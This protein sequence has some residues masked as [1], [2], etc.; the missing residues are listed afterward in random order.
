MVL[1]RYPVKSMGGEALER[2][3][4]DRRGLAGDRWY[5]VED[6]DGHLASGKNTRRFRRRDAVFDYRAR[7]DG[8]TVVVTGADGEWAAED[9]ALA[10]A[11]SAR[12]GLPVRVRS[13]S[14]VPHQDRGAVSLVGTATLDWCRRRWGLDADPRRL[15]VNVVLSTSV[16][17]AEEEWVGRRLALGGAELAVVER[18]PRCRMVDIDQDGAS[19]RGGWLRPLAAEREMCIAVY[20]DVVTGGAV[21]LGDT[22]DVR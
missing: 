6:K 20:A 22:A 12:M 21:A 1:R 13:E 15:R 11:L 4:F 9:P 17:F 3:V 7:T 2:A 8:G 10:A 19:A 18:A 14:E 16:P 5:A